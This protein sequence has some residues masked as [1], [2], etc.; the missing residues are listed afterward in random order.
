MRWAVIDFGE[1]MPKFVSSGWIHAGQQGFSPYPV[2][3]VGSVDISERS[4]KQLEELLALERRIIGP[5]TLV[6][7]LKPLLL[8]PHKLFSGRTYFSVH[9]KDEDGNRSHK[10]VIDRALYSVGGKGVFPWIEIG[11]YWADVF[12][13]EEKTVP[14]RISIANSDTERKLFQLLGDLV[15]PGGHMMVPYELD[16][17]VLSRMTFAALHKGVP[18]VA[19]PIGFLLFRIGFTIP[20]RD[21]YIA[22]GGHEGPRKLHFEKP[23]TERREREVGEEITA[24][25]TAFVDRDLE[26]KDTDLVR[27]CK[28][29]ARK[30][31]DFITRNDRGGSSPFI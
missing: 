16:D 28:N 6:I 22:E 5:Y 8:P 4:K 18:M 7:D 31:K 2:S 1:E 21:W 20:F 12:F 13:S 9:L 10:P 23:L 30:I 3:R 24:E 11:Y 27:T 14:K 29:N 26:T 17:N 25:L 19:T 15:P